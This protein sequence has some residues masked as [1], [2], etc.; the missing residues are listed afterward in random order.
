MRAAISDGVLPESVLSG[1]QC[2]PDGNSECDSGGNKQCASDG[3]NVVS[4]G[5]RRKFDIP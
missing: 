5:V 4:K 2:A 1:A 3:N